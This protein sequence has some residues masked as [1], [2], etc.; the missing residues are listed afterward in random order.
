ME[1]HFPK[2]DSDKDVLLEE[3]IKQFIL[4]LRMMNIEHEDVVCRFFSYTFQGKESTWFFILALSSITSWK[5]FETT[6]M[7][8]FRDEKTSGILFLKLSRKNNRKEKINDFNQIFITLLNNIPNNPAEAMQIEFYIVT[9]QPPIS[10]FVKM[11]KKQT[12]VENFEQDIKVEKDIEAISNH[13]GNEERK[14]STSQKSSKKNKGTSKTESNKKETCPTDMESMQ[15][16]I[17]HLTNKIIDLKKNNGEGNKPFKPFIKKRTNI[18][19][20][21][22]IPPTLGINLECYG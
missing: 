22:Q 9:L 18:D 11:E 8:Q 2:F 21:P 10:M 17:K 12:L 5:H 13:P 6:F 16:T 4:A 7:T 15:W 20:T 19:T 14:Y 3:H 1:N